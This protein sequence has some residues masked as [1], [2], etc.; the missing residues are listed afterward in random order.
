[1]G[2]TPGVC[3]LGSGVG[4]GRVWED[5]FCFVSVFPSSGLSSNFARLSDVT[6]LSL[7]LFL[8]LF[9]WGGFSRMRGKGGLVDLP[10]AHSFVH[11]YIGV[12]LL[13]R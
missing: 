1:V 4:S 8:S 5:G 10:I 2:M 11:T 12:S 3:C 7:S 13:L 9:Y 6:S